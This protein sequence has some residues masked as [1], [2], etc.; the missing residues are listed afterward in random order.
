MIN[1]FDLYIKTS[2]FIIHNIIYLFLSL[3]KFILI[4]LYLKFIIFSL[5]FHFKNYIL[6][7]LLENFFNLN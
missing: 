3:F 5:I 7:F 2:L 6:I 4:I 1:K